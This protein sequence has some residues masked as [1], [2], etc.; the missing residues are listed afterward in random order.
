[1]IDAWGLDGHLDAV[2][3][4]CEVGLVKPD[5]AIFAL[6]L[7]RLGGEPARAVLVDDVVEYLDAA[8]RLGVRTRRMARASRPEAGPHRVVSSLGGLLA[9]LGPDRP[10]PGG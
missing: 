1:M 2:V 7:R 6:A 8:A 4:S 10:G 3:L 5:P 9:G